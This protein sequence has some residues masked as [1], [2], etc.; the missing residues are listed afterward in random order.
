MAILFVW[1]VVAPDVWVASIV[2]G[3]ILAAVVASRRQK[4]DGV[5]NGTRLPV[6]K[7]CYG[8]AA[9]AL[10]L[11][12][13]VLPAASFYRVAHTIQAVSL[14]K[15]GQLRLALAVEDRD[16]RSRAVLD[17]QVQVGWRS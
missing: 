1:L 2:F 6:T 17:R 14:V 11:T 5:T 8:L 9:A 10:A 13:V 3:A 15:Y 7:L 12:T 16:L 4:P